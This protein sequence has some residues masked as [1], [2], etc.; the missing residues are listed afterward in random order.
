VESEQTDINGPHQFIFSLSIT[1]YALPAYPHR[2]LSSD[3]CLPQSLAT[4]NFSNFLWPERASVYLANVENILALRSRHFAVTPL[5]ESG[6]AYEGETAKLTSS[7][8]NISIE[9]TSLRPIHEDG[10]FDFD[11]RIYAGSRP[12]ELLYTAAKDSIVDK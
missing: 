4:R 9:N 6:R 11:T 2:Y 10:A 1:T 8:V 7:K 5:G 12:P 3:F